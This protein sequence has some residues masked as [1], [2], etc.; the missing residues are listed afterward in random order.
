MTR[1]VPRRSPPTAPRRPGPAGEPRS[2]RHAALPGELSLDDYPEVWHGQA[3]RPSN[4]RSRL[5][6]E[7]PCE[8]NYADEW[9]PRRRQVGEFLT[10]DERW[11]VFQEAMGRRNRSK[12]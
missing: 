1:P 9:L 2:G 10:A 6:G 5:T 7:T 8:V 11:R 12:S 4:S 3:A